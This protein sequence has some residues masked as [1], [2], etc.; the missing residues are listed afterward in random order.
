VLSRP[1]ISGRV[2]IAPGR[3]SFDRLVT[4]TKSSARRVR[5]LIADLEAGEEATREA[6]VAQLTVIG[7]RAVAPL[8]ALATDASAS[9]M[10]R[11]AVLR[12]LGGIDG[13]KSLDAAVSAIDDPDPTVAIAAIGVVRSRLTD[14]RALLAVDRIAAA[15]MDA[16]RPAAIRIAAL[17]AMAEL[18]R[19]TVQPLYEALSRDPD[20]RIAGLAAA[21]GSPPPGA[22]APAA[23]LRLALDDPF[24]DDPAGLRQAM[25]TGAGALTL[26]ELHR[27]LERVRE[28][29]LAIPD[30]GRASWVALRGSVH[31]EL[32]ERGS[33]VGLYDLRETLER[34]EAPLPGEFLTA[35]SL[36]GDG[37]CL[38][39]MAQAYDRISP[40]D[41]SSAGWWTQHLSQSFRDIAARHKLTKRSAVMKRIARRWP[42]IL[43]Q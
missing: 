37:S 28:K 33:L 34:A 30:A 27:L 21:G 6:A 41:G 29:E 32:A 17:Q 7:A 26:P 40:H 5:E 18:D 24:P 10:A 43:H 38:E 35:L 12:A 23:V 11:Q 22:H 9:P 3:F 14:A 16:R 4:I 42:R 15:A 8:V 1:A 39:P 20:P 25:R 13:Q 2:R 31:L 36:A 19:A